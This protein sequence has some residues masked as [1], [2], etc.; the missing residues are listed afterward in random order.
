MLIEYELIIKLGLFLQNS[1]DRKIIK[2]RLSINEKDIFIRTDNIEFGELIDIE[3]FMINEY[4][5][6]SA[7]ILAKNN[8]DDEELF[9]NNGLKILFSSKLVN[10][11][12]NWF[13]NKFLVI[14]RADIMEMNKK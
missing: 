14:Y 4:N 2:E 10:L 7:K 6:K 1:Y 13:E 3:Q 8:L 11:I 9:L 12:L 5:E